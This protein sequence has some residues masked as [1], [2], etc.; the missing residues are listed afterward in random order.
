MVRKIVENALSGKLLKPDEIAMLFD[1]P[2]FSY[3]SSLI[4]STA[5]QVCDKACGSLA[6]I[7]AQ[8]GLNISPCPRNCRFCS[9][10]VCN[11][12]FSG[13]EELLIE[14]V[15]ARAKGFESD[16]ANA[17]YLMTTA[18]YPFNRFIE[19]SQEVRMSLKPD[20]V[21]IANIDD[22]SENEAK[23]LKDVGF[24]GIYH[25][26]RMGEGRDTTISPKKRL[27]TFKNAMEAGL[28]IGTCVE[29][30]GSEHSTDEL[31]EKTVIT[32]DIKPV[33]SGAMRRTPISGTGL[34]KYGQVSQ[35]RM[36]HILAVVRLATGY[37]IPGNCTH[38]PNVVGVS[39]G[40]NIIWAET[41]ANPRD[42][43][44]ETQQKR[45]L[46]VEQCRQIFKEAE[47]DVL[48]GPSRFYGNKR[49]QHMPMDF[50][51]EQ[52]ISN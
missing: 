20:T 30:V 28:L 18:G 43:E 3:D 27:Q 46:T 48:S 50:D 32:R 37:S 38:E 13:T 49:G 33:F 15:V 12:V 47:W 21:L 24:T 34:A 52:S 26:I 1:V 23:R 45:G 42:T 36:A 39:S 8:I 35:S 2:L 7:H 5:R 31:V 14:D 17:I 4:Q 11:S 16:G 9:F 19:K 25:A 22:F 10:A 44:K 6:E 51:Y 41:G 29:P 40:A